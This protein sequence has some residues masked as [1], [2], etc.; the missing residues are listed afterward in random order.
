MIKT[1]KAMLKIVHLEDHSLL[2]RQVHFPLFFPHF[3]GLYFGL[4]RNRILLLGS[5]L[6]YAKLCLF[7]SAENENSFRVVAKSNWPK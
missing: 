3:F 4:E 5:C 7:L 6:L 2:V 1:K